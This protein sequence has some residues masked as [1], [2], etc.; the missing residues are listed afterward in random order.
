MK[1]KEFF[2]RL[3]DAQVAEAIHQA[4]AQTSGEI[5]VFVT[6]H[7]LGKRDVLD[8]AARCFEKLKMA[9]TD[10]RNGVL[11]YFAPRDQRFAILGDCG[12]D[13]KCGSEFW[14]AIAAE[15]H[16]ELA[17]GHFTE[18]VVAAIQRT[19]IALAEHFPRLPDDQNELPDSVKRD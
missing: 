15:L 1:P 12:I 4:E 10:A 7:A 18:A 3:D 11:L 17:E 2:N 8:E 13:E 19:G 14:N 6:R 5:R 16:R 9:E